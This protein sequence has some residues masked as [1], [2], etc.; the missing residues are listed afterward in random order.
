MADTA[1]AWMADEIFKLLTG[2]GHEIFMY[3]NKGKRVY[4]A[5]KASFLYS[6]PIKLMVNLSYTKGKPPKPLVK[7]YLSKTTPV[8]LVTQMKSTLKKH[9]L[10]DHSFDTYIY[11]KTLKPKHFVHHIN[12]EETVT[13]SSWSGTTRTS[14]MNVGE[15]QVVI[16]HNQRLDDSEN[17]PRWTRIR[18]IFIHAPDGSRYR[19]PHKHITGARAIAQHMDQGN[20]PW[21]EKGQAIDHLIRVLL[22]MRKVRRWL[23]GSGDE[24]MHTHALEISHGIKNL[25]R[26][27]GQSHS[28][29]TG[30]DQAVDNVNTWR[31]S[32]SE[33]TL[34][35]WPEGT[36]DAAQAMAS[37]Q[38]ALD[39]DAHIA[40]PDNYD[41]DDLVVDMFPEQ[42]I[43]ENWFRQFDMD[44]IF[45]ADDVLQ[46]VEIARKDAGTDDPREVYLSL[47]D[48]VPTWEASFER[49]PKGTLD[50]IT[51]ALKKLKK[52]D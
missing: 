24:G 48:A 34:L 25:L 32:A 2:Q 50:D 4:D 29:N 28:Y 36:H 44:T 1:N 18:D 45:E 37:H 39:S 6:N 27:I 38:S 17:T 16:R 5:S 21:D 14:R 11:G 41:E 30:V 3:D 47:K 15:T 13:E 9:N 19:C 7:F 33:P 35:N 51:S 10:Y 43:M 46:D 20:A 40:D 42:Q 8:N 12:P 23:Q 22:Q 31:V 26:R 52:S 49:D